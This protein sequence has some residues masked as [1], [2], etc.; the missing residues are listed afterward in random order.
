MNFLPKA[1]A[2]DLA[3]VVLPTPGGPYKHKI[4]CGFLPV[5]ILTDRYS[6]ILSLTLSKPKWFL[7]STSFTFLISL[8]SLV[9]SFQGRDTKNSRYCL[10]T[11]LSA[12]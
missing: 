2:I 1:S 3:R 5:K 6:R 8:I 7:S 10:I 12:I 11:P 4:V 9:S